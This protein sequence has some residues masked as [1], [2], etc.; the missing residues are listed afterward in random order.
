MAPRRVSERITVKMQQIE[1]EQRILEQE[2]LLKN[3]LKA[4]EAE[5]RQKQLEVERER[6]R[7]KRYKERERIQEGSC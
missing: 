1:N 4:K 6:E 5:E 2:R 7:E 3:Q